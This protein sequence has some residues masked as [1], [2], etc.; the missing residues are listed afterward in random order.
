MLFCIPVETKSRDLDGRVLLARQLA[1][2]GHTCL[3]GR[4]K[5]VYDYTFNR[6]RPYAFVAKGPANR[7]GQR[8]K[9]TGGHLIVLDEEGGVF[10]KSMSGFASRTEDKMVGDVE[11]YMAWG[12][13]QKI[14]DLYT[15][16]LMY[17][18]FLEEERP[19]IAP[20]NIVVSGNPRFDL[21]APKWHRYHNLVST[22][23]RSFKDGYFLINTKFANVNH[24]LGYEGRLAFTTKTIG[25]EVAI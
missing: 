18:T 17:K 12:T 19:N 5:G 24:Q 3:L 4:K 22:A 23:S 16:Y 9:E 15:T 11:L 7:I 8:I 20:G 25:K 2:E 13:R 6:Q 14:S 21:C 10:A 1:L